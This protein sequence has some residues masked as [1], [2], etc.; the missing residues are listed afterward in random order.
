MGFSEIGFSKGLSPA[1][2]FIRNVEYGKQHIKFNYCGKYPFFGVNFSFFV[3]CDPASAIL[4]K[5]KF[6]QSADGYSVLLS[7]T[8]LTDFNLKH[9]QK[10]VFDGSLHDDIRLLKEYVIKLLDDSIDIN[11]LDK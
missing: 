8:Q 5:F 10:A 6:K 4:E 2:T 1:R 9:K 3:T 11:G 7:L